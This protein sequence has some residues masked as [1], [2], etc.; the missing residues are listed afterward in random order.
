MAG[1]CYSKVNRGQRNKSDFYQTPPS[2]VEKLLE[3][4]YFDKSKNILEPCEGGGAISNILLKKGHT[5]EACDILTGSDF[6]KENRYN[7]YI[8]TNPPYSLAK[9]FIL[10]S[11][12]VVEIKFAML[13]PLS[14]LHGKDR[15]ET[16]FKN[17]TVY[18]LV[19]VH[20]FTRCPMLTETIREDGKYNTGMQIYA[21]FIWEKVWA[22]SQPEPIITWIDNNGDVKRKLRNKNAD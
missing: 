6:L 19:R 17:P 4:E 20:V 11:I 2:M 15:Y 13:L 8:I 12:D 18:P 21:W 22:K 1:K 3:I 16:F 7:P 10:H 9:E 5:V 14:Y